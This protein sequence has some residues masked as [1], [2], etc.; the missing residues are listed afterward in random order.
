MIQENSKSGSQI[1]AID[2]GKQL[3]FTTELDQEKKLI[4][5]NTALYKE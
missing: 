2:I 5:V 4:I 1:S 3:M